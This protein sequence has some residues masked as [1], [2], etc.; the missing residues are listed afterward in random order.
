MELKINHQSGI[1]LHMQ[2]EALIR[3]L[4]E[5]PEFKNGAFLPKEV[6]LANRLGVSRNT[7]RQATN[8][9][10]YEGKL[11]RKKGVGTKVAEKKALSTG[12]D[13]WYSFT[14]EM[15][16]RGVHVENLFVKAE[17]VQADKKIADFF[18]IR[19]NKK[20]LKLSKLKGTDDEPIVFF[21]SYF[22]P[23]IGLVPEDDYSR[24]LYS[25][26]EEKF[27]VLVVRS[28]ENISASLA[29]SFSKRLKVSV[30]DPILIRERYVY[31]P[32]DRPIEYNLGYYR[33]D[34]FSY[35]I[36]IRKAN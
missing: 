14:Q 34:K 20:I 17:Y 11:V 22:H 1:P 30:H 8:K 32:G 3:K 10:E 28:N 21:E 12:L 19:L 18:N 36:D 31:D 23:R 27:G 9:L 24:P 4:I 15:R 29:G 7:I 2:V 5:T 16:E 6:E 33:A 25:L 35:S 26:L 13:H